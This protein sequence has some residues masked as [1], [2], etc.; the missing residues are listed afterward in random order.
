MTT[1]APVGD[2]FLGAL[3]P[4]NNF[5]AST[6]LYCGWITGKTTEAHRACMK[7]NLSSYSPEVVASAAS[8]TINIT[9][10]APTTQPAVVR[11]ITQS[12]WTEGTGNGSATG[13]G[14]TWNRINGVVFWQLAGGV[15]TT[16]DEAFFSI[17][18]VTGPVVINLLSLV[19]DAIRNRN[20]VLEIMFMRTIESGLS[21]ECQF[22]S[23]ENA[24]AALRP[25]LQ[26]VTGGTRRRIT[27]TFED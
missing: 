25:S 7:F 16:I 13:D 15:F 4:D 20:G 19:N 5:G 24:T 17:P 21:S 3:A 9:A 26:V 18:N 23:R 8:L 27:T 11:R 6:S 14:A 2:N 12:G 22:A 10:A 1:F